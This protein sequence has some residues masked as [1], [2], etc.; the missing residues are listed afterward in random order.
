MVAL[1]DNSRYVLEWKKLC[2]ACDT[3][4]EAYLFHIGSAG[5][6]EVATG[7]GHVVVGS[8]QEGFRPLMRNHDKG[9]KEF[10]LDQLSWPKPN[11]TVTVDEE[12]SSVN[13]EPNGIDDHDCILV[14]PCPDFDWS[15][16]SAFESSND[17]CDWSE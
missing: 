4:E 17:S 14:N 13:S 6:T 10:D 2:D 9:S 3:V 7:R 11:A 16:V 15:V 5:S 8:D 1:A 12:S